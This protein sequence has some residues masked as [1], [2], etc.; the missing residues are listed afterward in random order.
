MKVI[1]AFLLVVIVIVV[2]GLVT[3]RSMDLSAWAAKAL[4]EP[5]TSQHKNQDT[6]KKWGIPYKDISVKTSDNLTIK[7]WLLLHPKSQGRTILICH[8]LWDSR[9]GGV[10]TALDLYRNG[11]FNVAMFDFRRH[12]ESSRSL[13]TYGY[14]EKK[15]VFAVAKFVREHTRPNAPLGL[16]GWSAGGAIALQAA[17]T[18]KNVKAVVTMNAFSTLRSAAM[19]RKPFVM[20]QRSFEKGLRLAEK[21]GKFKVAETSPLKSLQQLKVPILLIVGSKDW[22]VPPRHSKQLYKANPTHSTLWVQKGYGHN[23][24]WKH[25]SFSSRVLGFFQKHLK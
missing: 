24:W 19:Y 21:K 2:A 11:S 8:G 16:I 5:G 1:R 18:L 4:L 23:N 20:S 9:W 17:P 10:G 25:P 12:G 22:S 13:F 7:G 15:D 14:H 3:L 6:P